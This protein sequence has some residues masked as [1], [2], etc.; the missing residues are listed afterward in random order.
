MYTCPTSSFNGPH[1]DSFLY[2]PYGSAQ[3]LETKLS[4]KSS[5][6][7]LRKNRYTHHTRTEDHHSKKTG[8]AKD[9]SI[10]TQLQIT[11]EELLLQTRTWKNYFTC[12]PSC[13][14]SYLSCFEVCKMANISNQSSVSSPDRKTAAK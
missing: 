1:V 5:L 14:F 4:Q 13:L 10:S 8:L 12:S 3:Y 6:Y 11:G 2:P 9:E 7:Y